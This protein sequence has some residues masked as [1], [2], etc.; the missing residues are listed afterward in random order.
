MKRLLIVTLFLWLAG[1]GSQDS[2]RTVEWYASHSAERTQDLQA[3]QSKPPSSDTAKAN[4]RNA[5][6]A[7]LQSTAGANP[8]RIK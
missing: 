4:C 8:V 3:C 1:C 7:E 5:E 2:A 6:A